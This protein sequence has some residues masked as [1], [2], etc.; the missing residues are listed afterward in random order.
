[1]EEEPRN[2]PVSL[3]EVVAQCPVDGVAKQDLEVP[4]GLEGRRGH[5]RTPLVEPKCP[6]W[7]AIGLPQVRGHPLRGDQGADLAWRVGKNHGGRGHVK[8]VSLEKNAPVPPLPSTRPGLLLP[9]SNK[10][11]GRE[12]KLYLRVRCGPPA[13]FDTVGGMTGEGEQA[14]VALN[15]GM[16]GSER[17]RVIEV[18]EMASLY[19]ECLGPM[20]QVVS[21]ATGFVVRDEKARPYLVTNR[22]VVTGRNSLDENRPSRERPGVWKPCVYDLGDEEYKPTWREHPDLG[23]KVDKAATEAQQAKQVT[24]EQERAA[25]AGE[26]Q[27]SRPVDQ[28]C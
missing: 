8:H 26:E 1:M 17:K 7:V 27:L 25:A 11:W 10:E 2:A 18:P 3:H 12:P 22:H 6:L 4:D 19:I 13:L 20:G 5:P 24:A 21:R 28:D 16:G 23:W 14:P 9:S 15:D